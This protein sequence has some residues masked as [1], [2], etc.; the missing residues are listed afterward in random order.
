MRRAYVVNALAT[1]EVKLVLA[2][3]IAAP[4]RLATE[5]PLRPMLRALALGPAGGVPVVLDPT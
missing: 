5:R 4:L 2:E 3:V 1:L